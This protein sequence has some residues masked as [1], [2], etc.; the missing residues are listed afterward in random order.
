M[1]VLVLGAHFALVYIF[2]AKHGPPA[3]LPSRV[4]VLKIAPMAN[5][6]IALNDPTLYALPHDNDF[7]NANWP[8][9]TSDQPPTFRWKET[10]A[11]LC[12]SGESLTK[13]FSQFMATNHGDDWSLNFKPVTRFSDPEPPEISTLP[14]QSSLHLRGELAQYRWLNPR[15]LPDWPSLEVIAPSKVQVVVDVAGRVLS[16]VLLPPDHGLELAVRNEQADRCALEIARAARFFPPS[17]LIVGQM[18]FNWHAV[19]APGPASFP[20]PPHLP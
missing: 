20:P 11:W 2:G 19:P 15:P 10:P 12:L 13:T 18:I 14:Q 16:A 6:F 7:A 3:R 9:P 5:P 1:V 17:T 8:K 4:P